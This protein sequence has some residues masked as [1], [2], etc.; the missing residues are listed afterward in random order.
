M[1]YKYDENFENEVF[2]KEQK[3]ARL[4]ARAIERRNRQEWVKA[5]K[6]ANTLDKNYC[7]GNP[8]GYITLVEFSTGEMCQE[9][10]NLKISVIQKVIEILK[11]TNKFNNEF[12][13]FQ[14]NS[15]N[16]L[17]VCFVSNEQFIEGEAY[18]PSGQPSYIKLPIE[19]AKRWEFLSNKFPTSFESFQIVKTEAAQAALLEYI[20]EEEEYENIF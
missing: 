2:E 9:I 16:K 6:I 17:F 7:Y 18:L 12:G 4:A 10:D 5:K 1:K 8:N 14:A 13:W 15:E 19:K 20:K 3:A 11:E